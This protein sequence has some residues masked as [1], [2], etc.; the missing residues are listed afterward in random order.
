MDLVIEYRDACNETGSFGDVVAVT[1]E[2]IKTLK[3]KGFTEAYVEI[4]PNPQVRIDEEVRN[5]LVDLSV[6]KCAHV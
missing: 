2:R 5:W 6:R 1:E 4:R 3:E